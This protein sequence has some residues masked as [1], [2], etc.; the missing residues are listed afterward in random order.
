[1][2]K[3]PVIILWDRVFERHVLFSMFGR[4]CWDNGDTATFNLFASAQIF[5]QNRNCREVYVNSK[6]GRRILSRIGAKR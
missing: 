6:I 4:V 2:T 1:M 5:L 3:L